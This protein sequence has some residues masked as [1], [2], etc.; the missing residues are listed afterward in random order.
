MTPGSHGDNYYYHLL[1]LYL[2]WR[3]E[4]EDL[5]GE[6]STAQ[7]AL[8]VKRHQLQ[9][10]NSEFS[11][12]AD[13]VQQAVQ[14]LSDLHNTYGD[15]L[16]APIAPS[17]V[18][19]TLNIEA[20]QEMEFDA[21]FDGD[22]NIEEGA[23]NSTEMD[24]NCEVTAQEH[25]DLQAALFDDRDNNILSRRRMTDAEYESKMAG[26]NDSQRDALAHVIQYTRA[27]H[28]FFMREQDTLPNPLH[29][30]LTGGV[31]T[32]KSHVISVIKEH[33]E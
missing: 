26:L 2:P 7:E 4:A 24:Q 29:L 25:G 33:I 3:Q 17:A 15:N 9:F 32:G 21:M 1:M 19:D 12:F 31:G 22:I 13:K 20:G 23:I 8:L 18:Q 27:R 10:L 6:H 14:Q 28:Q 11:S 30:F 5:L 16:Y